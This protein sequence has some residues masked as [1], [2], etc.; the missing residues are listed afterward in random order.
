MRTLLL[1]LTLIII[2]YVQLTASLHVA[3]YG[4]LKHDHKGKTC[5]IYLFCDHQKLL[6]SSASILTKPVNFSYIFFWQGNHELLFN[7]TFSGFLSRAPPLA[8]I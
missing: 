8:I 1:R 5:E 2:A 7:K 4:V 3:A 6:S